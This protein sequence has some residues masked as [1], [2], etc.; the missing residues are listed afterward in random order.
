M[1]RLSALI[2]GSAAWKAK[3]ARAAERA[4]FHRRLNEARGIVPHV[5]PPT[6]PAE[7]D[8]IPPKVRDAVHRRD[9][10]VCTQ[11][12]SHYDLHL[13]HRLMRSQGGK[14]TLANLITLCGVCHRDV[15]GNPEASLRDGL[16]LYSSAEPARVPVWRRTSTGRGGRYLQGVDGSLTLVGA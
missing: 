5:P 14:H 1:S 15:H 3:Q 2:P 16:L 6:D 10:R 13:H 12:P 8:D 4:E 9:G 7:A 11:C